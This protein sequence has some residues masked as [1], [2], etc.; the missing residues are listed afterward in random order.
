[1]RTASNTL[2]PDPEVEH[3]IPDLTRWG[4]RLDG[5]GPPLPLESFRKPVRRRW[6][7]ASGT[8]QARPHRDDE[9]FDDLHVA[10]VQ[11]RDRRDRHGRLPSVRQRL[12]AERVLTRR[13]PATRPATPLEE[14]KAS[15]I[16]C[17]HAFGPAT[18]A[19][20]GPSMAAGRGAATHPALTFARGL[21]SRGE[22]VTSV[23]CHAADES[24]QIGHV[25]RQVARVGREPRLP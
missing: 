17:R 23:P 6:P 18:R 1:M 24:S 2:A 13:R 19:Q 25:F 12:A 21:P 4:C 7:T 11:Q 8:Q 10:R 16:C 3:E 15:S 5:R 20:R 22:A 9:A 14:L